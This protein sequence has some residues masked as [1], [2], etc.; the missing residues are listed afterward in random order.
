MNRES[1]ANS[2]TERLAA[3]GEGIRLRILRLLEV[4][5]LSVGEVAKVVQLP[6]STVSRHLKVLSDGGWLQKRNQ[7]TATLYRLVLDDLAI[8]AR[9][10]WLTVRDQMGLNADITEDACRL[11]GVL[12][13]RRLDSQAFFGRVAGEW[14][15]VRN[16]LF[17]DRFMAPAL[18]SLLPRHWF[19]AD[20]GCGTGNAAEHLAPCVA[21]VIAVDSSPVMLAAARQRLAGTPNVEF[22]QSD[23]V[24]LT[25]PDAS[26]DAALLALVLHHLTDPAAAL[27]EARRILRP[28]GV[29][30][31]V[32]MMAHDRAE[33]RHSMGHKHLGF[34]AAAFRGTLEQAGFEGAVIRDLPG[35]PMARG[36]GLFVATA[37]RPGTDVKPNRRTT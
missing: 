18:L 25:L 11:A 37:R 35:D 7:G 22:L 8:Q 16:E 36:P 19:V 28:G 6:Q 10:L 15:Q 23:L 4:Q 24:A 14:D 20:L 32:D 2:I 29:I 27:R 34:E 13:E 5:E 9:A 17:G 31:V 12:A 30:L 1:T 21:R 3:L 26:V 33:Y